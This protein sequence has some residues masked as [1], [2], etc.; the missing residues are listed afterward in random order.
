M[1]APTPPEFSK[2]FINKLYERNFFHSDVP[3][4]IGDISEK[5]DIFDSV[6]ALYAGKNLSAMNEAQLED[7]VIKP[8]LRL[9][10]WYILLTILIRIVR[11]LQF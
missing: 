8:V 6:K 11:L 2:Y 3:G 7:A 5:R 4:V 10:G 1:S 9:L